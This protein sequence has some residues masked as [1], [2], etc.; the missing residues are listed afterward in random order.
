MTIALP[1]VTNAKK[2]DYEPVAL[3]RPFIALGE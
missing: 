1:V 3:Q 2:A